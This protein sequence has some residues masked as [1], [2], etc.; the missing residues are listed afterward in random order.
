[1]LEFIKQGK[2]KLLVTNLVDA[3]VIKGQVEEF[4]QIVK[5]MGIDSS[6][7]IFAQ[8]NNLNYIY[9]D[10][11]HCK[12]KM[13]SGMLS[14][15]QAA[16]LFD[17]YPF[18]YGQLN[19]ICDIF[20]EQ[21]LD[22]NKLRSKKFICFNRSMNRPHRL[23]MA[24]IA[25]KHNLLENGIF[26]FIT[27]LGNSDEIAN[28]F[29]KIYPNENIELVI[30]DIVNLVP[31]ELDTQILSPENKQSFQTIGIT[32][33]SWY[34]DSYI[35]FVSESSFDESLDPFFSEKTWRPIIN[36]QPFL[37]VGNCNSLAKLKK[38]GFKTF[39]PFIDESYD[40]EQDSKKRFLMIE[41]EIVKLNAL[42]IE[43]IH[44]WYYSIV[45]I[46]LYNQRHLK[47]FTDYDPYE[48]LYK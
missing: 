37:F 7:V 27:N 12:I 30:K 43:E 38:L 11:S 44:N 18:Y 24:H 21:D 36:L 14:L 17:R 4:E 15:Y 5:G 47:T 1:M 16:E 20:K 31:Y 25:L 19:Y 41:K 34:E 9:E 10:N 6:N 46:L 23:A 39:H 28:Q 3:S 13:V 26:S 35:H 42:S 2:V 29:V 8:G 22:K 45:D 40:L 32:K 48:E 33:K